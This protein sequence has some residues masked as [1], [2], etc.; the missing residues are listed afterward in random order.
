MHKRGRS[1]ER[2]RG[3]PSKYP[4]LDLKDAEVLEYS[5]RLSLRLVQLFA[6]GPQ[7]QLGRN[8]LTDLRDNM[9]L[10]AEPKKLV[11]CR[12]ETFAKLLSFELLDGVLYCSFRE[13]AHV[14]DDSMVWVSIVLWIALIPKPKLNFA[15]LGSLRSLTGQVT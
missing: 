9:L 5:K 15:H 11:T 13:P 14:N 4:K 10:P 12:L 8:V 3:S 2:E 1:Q 6:S 7:K